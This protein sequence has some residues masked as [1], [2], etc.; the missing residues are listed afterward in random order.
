MDT[1]SDMRDTVRIARTLRDDVVEV[2]LIVTDAPFWAE[3]SHM[4]SKVAMAVTSMAILGSKLFE[5]W[6]D[7]M[8]VYVDT[9]F[10]YGGSESFRWIHSCHMYAIPG[11]FTLW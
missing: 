2:R 3:R 11:S 5:V 7:R 6:V 1:F 10:K 8:S 4:C 9:L